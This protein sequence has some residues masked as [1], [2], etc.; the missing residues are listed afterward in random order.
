MPQLQLPGV[1]FKVLFT[2]AAARRFPL[3]RRTNPHPWGLAAP[4][5]DPVM[6]AE[7]GWDRHG[8]IRITLSYGDPLEPSAPL[9]E[10]TTRL[11]GRTGYLR[12]PQEA[13][14]RLAHRDAA[15][16]RRDWLA[17]DDDQAPDPP[18]PAD[19]G[20]AHLVLGHE[21]CPVTV[22]SWRHYQAAGFADATTAGVIASRHCP[23]GQL[24]LAPVPAI[25]SYLTGHTDFLRRLARHV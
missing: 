3:L 6:L 15:V 9:V 2:A 12:T 14:A 24:T 19:V 20:D 16:E 4:S 13:L 11:P 23:L 25:E 17:F 21:P 10:I 18:G 22:L 1:V 5:L 8:L 7:E